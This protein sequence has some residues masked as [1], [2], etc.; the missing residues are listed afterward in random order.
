LA[1]DPAIIVADEP[2][3]NLDSKSE[4]QVIDILTN[5]N[6]EKGKT[7]VLV[8]HE[9]SIGKKAPKQLFLK[10]GRIERVVGFSKCDAWQGGKK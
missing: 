10:D 5:L 4:A 3:G 1:M 2:T 9:Q 7:I 6:K 8:T